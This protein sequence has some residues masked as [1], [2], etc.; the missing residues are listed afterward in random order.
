MIRTPG[1]LDRAVTGVIDVVGGETLAQAYDKLAGH[2]ILV[3]VGSAGERF[4]TLAF[5]GHDGRHDR[6]VT[7]FFLG[8]YAGLSA[9]LAWLAVRVT[10]NTLTPHIARRES[11]KDAGATVQALNEGRL[12]GKIVL[13]IGR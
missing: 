13:D 9:D 8:A 1:Q 6:S 11:W 7:S 2:G 5:P 3:S 4:P 10:D 12:R